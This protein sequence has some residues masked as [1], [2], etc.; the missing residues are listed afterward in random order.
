[1]PSLAEVLWWWASLTTGIPALC[2]SSPA[3]H[4]F[5][6]APYLVL[7]SGLGGRG[8]AWSLAHREPLGR[9]EL[10][11]LHWLCHGFCLGSLLCFWSQ[12]LVISWKMSK[13]FLVWSLYEYMSVFL[14]GSKLATAEQW[15]HTEQP[16]S[17]ELNS[18]NVLRGSA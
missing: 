18:L 15:L 3:P 10:L 11:H 1:M 17:A 16:Y 5:V 8:G 14:S 12:L 13:S 4:A 9:N 6:P 2:L 7:V